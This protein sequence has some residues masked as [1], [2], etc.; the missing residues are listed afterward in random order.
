MA[1]DNH[2]TEGPV[3][4]YEA[5][6]MANEG[7]ILRREKIVWELHW[8]L[9]LPIPLCLVLTGMIL[10]GMGSKPA[11]L[12]V[13]LLPA[14]LVVLFSFLWILFRVLRVHVTEQNVHIQYGILGPQ[15]PV[16]A[17]T[18]CRVVDYEFS[19]YGGWGIRYG[20]DG[21]WAY[22]LAGD[23]GRV[24]Q[25]CWKEGGKEKKVVVSSQDPDALAAAILLAMAGAAPRF[26]APTEASSSSSL[27]SSSAPAEEEALLE[28]AHCEEQIC[29]QSESPS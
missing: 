8:L 27:S 7:K 24:V 15:I 1:A 23:S 2:G 18:S 10:A 16:A 11:P 5:R 20:L 14:G 19:N 9:L 4:S 6:Y 28:A 29:R 3:D 25:I 21:S 17:I 13:A 12:P 26:R 22:S